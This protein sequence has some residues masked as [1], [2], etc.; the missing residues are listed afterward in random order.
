[1]LLV[2]GVTVTNGR[3]PQDMVDALERTVD[4]RAL[5]ALEREAMVR[6]VRADTD[7]LL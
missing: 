1:M 3:G 7:L 4:D 6:E 5:G 2:P